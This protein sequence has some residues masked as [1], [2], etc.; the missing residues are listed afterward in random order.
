MTSC[1]LYTDSIIR[2]ILRQELPND[3][4][5]K[6]SERLKNCPKVDAIPEGYIKYYGSKKDAVCKMNLDDLIRHFHS[7]SGGVNGRVSEPERSE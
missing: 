7:D 2:P 4:Y 6:V 3:I 1:R 5:K